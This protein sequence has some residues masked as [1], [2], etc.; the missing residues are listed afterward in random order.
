M[1]GNEARHE[2]TIGI[3]KNAGADALELIKTELTLAR[4]ELHENL[5]DARSS[6]VALAGAALCGVAGLELVL[7]AFIASERRRPAV[8]AGVGVAFLAGAAALGATALRVF[9]ALLARTKERAERD[10]T[11]IAESLT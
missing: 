3:V 8:L 11:R 7:G 10:V 6:A 5:D 2:S 1:N 4:R 9:P